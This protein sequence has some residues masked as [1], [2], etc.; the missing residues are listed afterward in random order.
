MAEPYRTRVCVGGGGYPEKQ[1]YQK[2]DW[3]PLGSLC[4]WNP[5]RKPPG[6]MSHR[7]KMVGTSRSRRTRS[8]QTC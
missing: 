8:T 7:T 5:P 4:E 2:L 6:G 3:G 1:T